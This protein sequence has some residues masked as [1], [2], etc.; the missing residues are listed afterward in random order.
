M[1][2]NIAIAKRNIELRQ[3]ENETVSEG[4]SCV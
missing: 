2:S 1:T 3:D 4:K